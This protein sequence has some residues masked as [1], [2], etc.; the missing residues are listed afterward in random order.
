MLPNFNWEHFKKQTALT[1]FGVL[2]QLQNDRC[3]NLAP[4]YW[5]HLRPL[6]TTPH[7][8]VFITKL[9]RSAS[10][11]P[12]RW[13]KTTQRKRTSSFIGLELGYSAQG[14]CLDTVNLILFAFLTGWTCSEGNNCHSVTEKMRENTQKYCS[15]EHLYA[16]HSAVVDVLE[17]KKKSNYWCKCR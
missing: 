9:M 6:I 10:S 11:D 1:V 13:I 17:F 3:C 15:V 4:S 2:H 14:H 12:C 16:G 8:S 7:T 5:E